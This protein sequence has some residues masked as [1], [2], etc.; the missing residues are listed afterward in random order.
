MPEVYGISALPN[1]DTTI[2]P[3]EK[4]NKGFKLKFGTPCPKDGGLLYLSSYTPKK[5]LK[6]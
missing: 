1:W 5:M 4:T 3:V 2:W 6:K